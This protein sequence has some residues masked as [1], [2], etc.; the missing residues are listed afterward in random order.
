MNLR[1]APGATS[2]DGDVERNVAS[3]SCGILGIMPMVLLTVC[4]AVIFGVGVARLHTDDAEWE[5]AALA[6]DGDRV[7]TE[8][9]H[10]IELIL[11]HRRAIVG[12]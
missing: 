2:S 4:I 5:G 3:T 8:Y 1:S 11:E 9:E 7:A 12:Y 10:S 6:A